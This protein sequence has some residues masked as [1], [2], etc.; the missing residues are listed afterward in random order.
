LSHMDVGLVRFYHRELSKQ[1][2]QLLTREAFN[3]VFVADD[4]EAG[5]LVGNGYKPITI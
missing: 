4:F 5:A 3:S 2:V 1:E